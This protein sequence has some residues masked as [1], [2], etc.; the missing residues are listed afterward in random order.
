MGRKRFQIMAL[1]MAGSMLFTACGKEKAADKEETASVSDTKDSKNSAEGSDTK[2]DIVIRMGHTGSDTCM[3]QL[4]YETMKEYMERESGG[5]IQVQI[6]SGGQL[7]DDAAHVTAVQN[8]DLEMIG[9][10]NGYM[11]SYQES[12]NIFSMPFAFK[13][14]VVAYAVLEGDWGKEMLDSLEEGCGLKGL[15][16]IDSFAYR[17]LTA[18]KPVYTPDDLKGVKIRVMP[19]EVHLA[20]WEALGAQPTAIAFS[21]LYTALQQGTVE[22]QENPFENIVTARL[23][24]VQKYVMLTNH[25]YTTGVVVAN[26]AWYN[27][28]D[29]EAKEIVQG[30]VDACYQFQKEEAAKREAE[31]KKTI[32]EAG[33]EIIELSDEQ[34]GVFEEAAKPAVEKITDMVGEETVNSLYDAI[35][36]AEKELGK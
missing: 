7:G 20:I 26:P 9:I 29:D 36:K 23:Y 24:E 27:S 8:G 14:Q 19:T 21:E 2:K 15:G 30:A 35:D 34:L 28:L 11:T 18:N 22:A 32:T 33:V 12:M 1:C 4:G 31:Y 10:N 3:M 5:R 6:F 16:Y 25:V 13:S 17:E